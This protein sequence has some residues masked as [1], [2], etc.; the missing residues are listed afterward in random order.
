MVRQRTQLVNALR[1][2]LA[3]FGV[4]VAKDLARAIRFAQGVLAGEE[5]ELPKIA[6]DVVHN[7]CGHLGVLHGQVRWYE[8]RLRL[9]AKREPCVKLLQTIRPSWACKHA[10]PGSETLALL[11]PL[12]SLQAL[13]VGTRSRMA[14][15]LQL[16]WV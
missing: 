3:E 13:G 8:N 11:R 2:M 7:L 15:N 4:P 16:G 12:R 10:L 9:E 5:F 6:Q 1:S 14:V